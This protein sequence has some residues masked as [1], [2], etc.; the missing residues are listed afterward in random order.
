MPTT[1]EHRIRAEHNLRFA[2]SF[3]LETTPYI[4]WVVVAYFY[5]ALHLVDALL[6]EKENLNPDTHEVRTA[7]VKN[8]WYLRAI[9]DEYRELKD[10][11]EDARYRLL[12]FTKRKV[13]ENV[14]PLYNTIANH[15][16]QQLPK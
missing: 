8:K 4:D 2:K 3:D 7:W 5:A 1:S 10:R 15:I 6:W 14:I 16:L 9:R 13:E 12:T 11:S